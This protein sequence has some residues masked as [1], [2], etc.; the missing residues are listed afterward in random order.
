MSTALAQEQQRGQESVRFGPGGGTY[1]VVTT[2]GE[3][4]GCHFAFEVAEPPGGGPPLHTHAT[5]DEY[6]AVFDGE[7]MF[8]ID[9]CVTAVTAGGSA[10]VPRGVPHCFKNCSTRDARML[11][12]FTPGQVEGF[13]D[14]GLPVNGQRPSDD[15]LIE[16][17]LELAPRFGIE[18][19]GP[20]PL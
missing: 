14:Y 19:L 17:I 3:T 4:T 9:G 11:V 2:A 12:L 10:F 18:V 13:F 6:F 20:S 1:R 16:R 15:R 7:F 5:E 8:Y